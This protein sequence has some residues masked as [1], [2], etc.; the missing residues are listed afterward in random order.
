MHVR[1]ICMSNLLSLPFSPPAS[2]LF[3]SS[4]TLARGK[5][6]RIDLMQPVAFYESLCTVLTV[7]SP[8]APLKV[9]ILHNDLSPHHL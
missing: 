7:L 5:D 6:Q 2:C 8:A 4:S 9:Y 3:N 1:S